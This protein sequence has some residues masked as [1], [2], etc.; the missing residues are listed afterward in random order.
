MLRVC[1]AAVLS[2]LLSLLWLL[3]WLLLLP[4][5]LLLV[6]AARADAAA[7]G[8][9]CELTALLDAA[10]CDVWVLVLLTES[11]CASAAVL[12]EGPWLVLLTSADEVV[13]GSSEVAGAGSLLLRGNILPYWCLG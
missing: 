4:F 9:C 1:A 2:P 13:V 3:L 6:P 10:S 7:S 5:P 8:S 11:C 12:A